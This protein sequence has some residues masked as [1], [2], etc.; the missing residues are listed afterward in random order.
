[1][2]VSELKTLEPKVLR[3]TKIEDVEFIQTLSESDKVNDIG[4][5]KV[6]IKILKRIEYRYIFI[7]FSV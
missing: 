4:C 1:M 2:E 7:K 5:V 3:P 6:C